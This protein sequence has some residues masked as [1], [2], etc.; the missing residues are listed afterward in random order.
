MG[1]LGVV[2]K[3]G[4]QEWG[5]LPEKVPMDTE[6]DASKTNGA[7]YSNVGDKS[8]KHELQMQLMA[9]NMEGI[10]QIIA[11]RMDTSGK[12]GFQLIGKS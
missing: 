11:H 2:G 1:L 5:N 3:K 7:V 12:K 4:M 9:E 8:L 6:N 10:M